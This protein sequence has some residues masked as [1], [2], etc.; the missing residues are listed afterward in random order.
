MNNNEE[1]SIIAKLVNQQTGLVE[2]LSECQNSKKT[3]SSQF[4]KILKAIVL[5]NNGE[6]LIEKEFFDSADDESIVLNI[7]TDD[8]EDILLNL[9]NAEEEE[10]NE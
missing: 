2:A 4:I 8:D 6:F 10:E 9:E 3:L 7:E 1:I 5:K